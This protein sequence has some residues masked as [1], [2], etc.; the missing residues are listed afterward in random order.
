MMRDFLNDALRLVLRTLVDHGVEI[1]TV[2]Y[3]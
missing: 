1:S 3:P 2:L